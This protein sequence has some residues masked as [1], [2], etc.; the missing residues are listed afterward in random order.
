M[1]KPKR[2]LTIADQRARGH[3]DLPFL[4]LT[5]LLLVIGVIMVLSASYA[6]AYY[7]STVDSPF[8]YFFHQIIFAAAG[9]AL[10]YLVSRLNYETFR[11]ASPFVMGIAII[12]LIIVIPF[13]TGEES[14]G[15]QRWLSLGP[16]TFQPSEIAKLGV[17]LMFAAWL[18]KRNTR[19]KR[20]WN[21]KLLI[22]R[23]A[24][25]LDRIGFL[26]LIPYALILIVVSVLMLLEPHVSGT[27]LIIIA[28]AAILLAAGIKL[29]WF[30]GAGVIT[31][32]IFYLVITQMSHTSARLAVWLDPW[33][34]PL[35]SGYQSIQSLLAI[36]SGGMLGLGLGNS[37]QKFL[38]LPEPENDFV[39]SIVCEELG[40]IGAVLIL[41]LF[42]LLIIRG[43]WLALHARD[44]F[45]SLLIIGIMTLFAAQV[46]FN[47]GVIT[48]L[49]PVTGISLPFFSYGG[50][51]L[52]I[53][54]VE[55]GIV[56]SISRQ[57]PEAPAK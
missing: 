23:I 54:L 33:V 51:A 1:E 15:A 43:Y 5:L 22:W 8:Y 12:L 27:I 34:D 13:G 47:V 31:G 45:G 48:G 32:G 42:A 39:F 36:G 55:M 38:Y 17:V 19:K 46:F 30:I 14:V 40:Y 6:S 35:E 52:L 3:M 28:G 57:I 18:S 24:D 21:K 50:T 7:D 53:Q 2:N 56:L 4:M 29:Y 49:L 26:E 44:R 10:M 37:R 20:N 41:I 11:A 9:V 25:F 16:F